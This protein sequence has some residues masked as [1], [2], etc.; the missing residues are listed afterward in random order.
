M[1][2]TARSLLNRRFRR[3]THEK[4]HQFCVPGTSF[5]PKNR[6]FCRKLP[7]KKSA[8][9]ACP[10]H[11]FF[12]PINRRSDPKTY[13][14]TRP[15]QGA[16]GSGAWAATT[17]PFLRG[18]PQVSRYC[19]RMRLLLVS[20]WGI[21]F[22]EPR[23]VPP[24]PLLHSSLPGQAWLEHHQATGPGLTYKLKIARSWGG[25][26]AQKHE[27]QHLVANKGEGLFCL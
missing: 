19:P 16:V 9:F 21:V 2:F 22:L 4:K 20:V 14:K 18:A 1:R 12:W 11:T 6:R 7:Y 24:G 17:R 5:E 8:F 27:L 3:E 25:E 13:P 15:P 23:G 26:F 10:S